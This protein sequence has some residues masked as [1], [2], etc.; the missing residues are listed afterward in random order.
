M[1]WLHSRGH[2]GR[3]CSPSYV[4]LP[5]SPPRASAFSREGK[6][7]SPT[8]SQSE[9]LL[10]KIHKAKKGPRGCCGMQWGGLGSAGQ[11]CE[12]QLGY[13]NPQPRW[14]SK[15][16]AGLMHTPDDVRDTARTDRGCLNQ[17]LQ[18]FR[19][20]ARFK[21]EFLCHKMQKTKNHKHMP[22]PEELFILWCH[23][24]RDLREI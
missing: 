3:Q 12:Q 14:S 15:T 24:A 1:S 11:V 22:P 8:P 23:S 18:G 13:C 9:E 5:D 17:R 6:A 10:F 21:R 2:E 16:I 4:Q 7:R 19:G 20:A